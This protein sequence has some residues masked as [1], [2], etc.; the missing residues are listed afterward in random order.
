MASFPCY[1]LDGWAHQ[2]EDE[3]TRRV[4]SRRLPMLIGS[5]R[6]TGD[7]SL[8]IQSSALRSYCACMHIERSLA[9]AATRSVVDIYS[10][11]HWPIQPR[12]PLLIFLSRAH[13]PIEVTWSASS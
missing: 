3:T 8:A 9:N 13:W 6:Y 10:S 2:H 7:Y 5:V 4:T 12:G 11:T 1:V